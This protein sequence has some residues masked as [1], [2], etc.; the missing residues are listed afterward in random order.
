MMSIHGVQ[1]VII[2][3]R[4][5]GTTMRER[6][7]QEA[8][9]SA[10]AILIA[11]GVLFILMILNGITGF[12]P[13]ILHRNDIVRDCGY[14]LFDVMAWADT[15]GNG[16]RESDEHFLGGVLV[17]IPAEGTY[18]LNRITTTEGHS[19]YQREPG[20]FAP[21]DLKWGPVAAQTPEGYRA[22]TP[23]RI[24]GYRSSYAFG[25]QPLSTAVP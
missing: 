22:T 15:N 21:C 18:N 13:A 19:E 11:G 9:T 6:F 1:C 20:N 17:S 8:E 10:Q 16:A 23:M 25:F 4:V 12:Y 2:G 14:P 5:V 3:Y 7:W 24:T